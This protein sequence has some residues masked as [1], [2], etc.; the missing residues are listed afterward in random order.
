MINYTR[1]ELPKNYTVRPEYIINRVCTYFSITEKQIMAKNRKR[2]IV[3]A[4][5]LS[6]YFIYK[7]CPEQSLSSIG[8]MFGNRDHTT[9]IHSKNTV[10]KFVYGPDPIW[11]DY[12]D[13]FHNLFN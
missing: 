7:L 12:H 11:K 10:V 9:V 1:Y 3:T 2:T 13:Y 8:R 4:R 5:M 6:M